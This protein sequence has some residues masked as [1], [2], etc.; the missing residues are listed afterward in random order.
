MYDIE[1]LKELDL[2]VKEQN[3]RKSEEG[4]KLRTVVHQIAKTTNCLIG[5]LHRMQVMYNKCTKCCRKMIH[6][7]KA[8]HRNYRCIKY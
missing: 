8:F 6:I 5:L 1:L 2:D 7:L 3:T 4:S